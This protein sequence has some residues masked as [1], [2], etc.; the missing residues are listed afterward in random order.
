MMASFD[1]TPSRRLH[2]STSD[3]VHG[4][5]VLPLPRGK[6]RRDR[7]IIHTLAPPSRTP[8]P[9]AGAGE[10]VSVLLLM[11]FIGVVLVL[12]FIALFLR[13]A[14]DPRGSNERDALLP[15]AVEKPR[16]FG[17]GREKTVPRPRN[18]YDQ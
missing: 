4:L 17:P 2:T 9:P 10:A 14:M 12:F 11:V 3:S 6:A 16:S 18:S 13:D 5:S 8:Q 15:L 7:S 1:E